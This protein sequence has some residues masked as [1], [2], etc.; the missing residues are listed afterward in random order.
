MT[1]QIH[2]LGEYDKRTSKTFVVVSLVL[3]MQS[4]SWLKRCRV[5]A[6]LHGFTF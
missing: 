5:A 4:A 3:L 6:R 1:F 2:A